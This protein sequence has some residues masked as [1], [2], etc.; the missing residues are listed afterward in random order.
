MLYISVAFSDWKND[1]EM[2]RFTLDTHFFALRFKAIEKAIQPFVQDN[3]T[4]QLHL[5]IWQNSTTTQDEMKLSIGTE[6]PVIERFG[7]VVV[8]A[9]QYIEQRQAYYAAEYARYDAEEKNESTRWATL[10]RERE[11]R[12]QKRLAKLAAKKPS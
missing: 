1:Q 3:R 4:P 7:Q 5:L 9:Q 6:V 10:E 12:R 11:E 2:L 8:T